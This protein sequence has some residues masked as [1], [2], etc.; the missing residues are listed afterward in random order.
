MKHNFNLKR[1]RRAT[2]NPK[3]FFRFHRGEFGHNFKKKVDLDRYYADTESLISCIKKTFKLKSNQN[4]ILGQGA[5]GLIKDTLMWHAM[6]SQKK[7]I[8]L[9]EPNYYMYEHYAKLFGYKIFKF[10]L[11]LSTPYYIDYLEIVK[12]VKNNKINLL[13][14]VNPSAPLEKKINQISLINLLKYCKKN[15]IFVIF[16]EVY[17]NFYEKSSINLVDKFENFIVIKTFSKNVGYPGLKAGFAICGKKVFQYLNSSRLSVE[18]SSYVVKNCIRILKSNI[19]KKNEKIIFDSI[20]WGNKNFLKI[21]IESL[22]RSTIWFTIDL[23]KKKIKERVLKLLSK[24]NILVNSNFDLNLKYLVSFTASYLQNLK[25]IF[26]TIKKII[27][28]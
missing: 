14:R 17:E 18:L 24:K 20:K 25:Y 15:K 16:D 22:S 11:N 21:G 10:K 5:E 6:T 3:Y 7:N 23:Q 4:I 2:P 8:L 27:K 26:K 12:F 28:P 13:A 19:I 1:I 9:Y